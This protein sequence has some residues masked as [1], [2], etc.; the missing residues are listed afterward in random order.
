MMRKQILVFFFVLLLG[1][2]ASSQLTTSTVLTPEQLVKNVLVGQGVDVFNITYTGAK[3]AIGQFDA[4]LSNV[5]IDNG[6]ILSTGNVLDHVL[7]G[8]KNGPVGPNNSSAAS[9]DWGISGDADLA[10]IV[11]KKTEDAAII[12]FD[13]IPQ[14]DTISFNYV[15]A[16]EEYVEYST[17]TSNIN[18]VFAF[19]I[20][21][22]GFPVPTNIAVLPGTTTPVSI[23]NV[24]DWNNTSFFIENGNG[25]SGT[26]YTDPTVVNFDGLTV[27]LTAIAKVTPCKVYHLK[28]ALA[29]VG[30]ATINSGV[31][32]EAGSLKSNP[33][34]SFNIDPIF[35][36]LNKDTLMSEG[37][38]NI[39]NT[40]KRYD[41]LYNPYSVGFRILGTATEGIDYT[42]SSN[43]INFPVN[44]DEVEF[45]VL[46]IAD[47]LNEG[48]ESVILRFPNPF[49]CNPDSF[50]IIY[51]IV[52][53]ETILTTT[54][55]SE[56]KC[57]GDE[58]EMEVIFSGG[59]PGYQFSWLDGGS[60]TS[61]NKVTPVSTK[62]YFYTLTDACGKTK[63]D[64]AV[65]TV[66]NFQPLTMKVSKD[67]IVY[68]I[69]VALDLD[70]SGNGGV[71]P[72]SFIWD[73][74]ET[75]SSV[76]K[77]ILKDQLYYVSLSDDCGGLVEGSIFVDLDYVSFS[78]ES[79]NDTV[80][81]YGDTAVL[82]ALSTGGVAPYQ[83]VWETGGLTNISSYQ[84]FDSKF[85][86]VT[87]TDSC[88]IISAVDSVSVTVQKPTAIFEIIAPK[89]EVFEVIYYENVSLGSILAYD[90][91]LGNGETSIMQ[92]TEAE[93]VVDSIYSIRLIVEDD[94]GCVDT[95]VKQV[96]ISPPL[97]FY[98]PNTFTPN[99]DL[100]NDVFL[101]KGI[102][103]DKFEL[104][105]YDRWG[106][107]VFSTK[108]SND[109]WDGSSKSGKIAPIGVYVYKLIIAGVSG[110]EIEK[111]GKITLIR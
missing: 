45:D 80:I 14:G 58:I 56:L 50:D 101:G 64:S 60:N 69:G 68:C 25:M 84:G 34:F 79:F 70:A 78:V 88:G 96:K 10:T 33:A 55:E 89:P 82:S 95:L 49:I 103:I 19:F 66:P 16:S 83:Y 39:R 100:R 110:E 87:A 47:N 15:F 24:N 30:D 28:L 86:K 7:G 108:D 26:Q 73:S 46:S 94:L 23:G 8:K 48:T 93:Y 35:N 106:I 43:Q 13:F 105:I 1:G 71:E 63:S 97:Y 62:T 76:S 74:G 2:S 38:S 109:G 59:V 72:Y 44:V 67:T 75:V 61:K 9:T 6:L 18:D 102:G 12:E 91:D 37:C 3:N 27:Q 32:L 20:S 54:F 29:D 77:T 92:D 98:L 85:V 31:F 40:F 41:K 36:P 81:C 52:D 4:S 99:N 11:N 104:I 65:I 22:P 42:L 17:S 90:W 21:G 53:Q 5:G 111:M 57:E 107:E 51:N